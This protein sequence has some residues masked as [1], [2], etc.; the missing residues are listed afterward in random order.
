MLC[1]W[2][3]RIQ[4]V[5]VTDFESAPKYQFESDNWYESEQAPSE[6]EK[7]GKLA[8]LFVGHASKWSLKLL[9]TC[10]AWKEIIFKFDKI[11]TL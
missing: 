1:L 11:N 2:P 9:A 6:L 7:S 8:L 3:D 4:L 10:K 5:K